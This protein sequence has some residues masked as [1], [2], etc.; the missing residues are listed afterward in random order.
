SLSNS[1]SSSAVHSVTW[2][3]TTRRA[4]AAI[5]T[6]NRG[7]AA[8][9]ADGSKELP[10]G[11]GPEGRAGFSA[12]SPVDGSAADVSPASGS[13]AVHK[14]LRRLTTATYVVTSWNWVTKS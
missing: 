13:V 1:P 9:D 2:S 3:Y 5:S 4:S 10:S 11:G 6:T 8:K 7:G 12:P 14:T